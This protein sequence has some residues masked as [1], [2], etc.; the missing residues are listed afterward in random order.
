MS[1]EQKVNATTG[2]VIV[3]CRVRPLNKKELAMG[4]ICCMDFNPNKKDIQI[5]MSADSGSAFGSNKF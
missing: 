3:A 1:E 4:S 2:N 5:N